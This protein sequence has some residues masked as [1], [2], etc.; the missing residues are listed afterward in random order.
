MRTFMRS[1]QMKRARGL[2]VQ[3][4]VVAVDDVRGG[5]ASAIDLPDSVADLVFTSSVLIH[6]HQDHLLSSCSEI[7]RCASRWIGCIE[8]FSDKPEMI[9]Y[10]GQDDQLFKCDLG[11]FWLDNFPDL[12]II[13]Y[14]F[15]WKRVTG[16]DNLTWWLFEKCR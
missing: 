4:G 8:Y 14:D 13:A 10:R 11:G 6:I 9:P 15:S 2:L 16:L 12:R 7:H 5:V 3:D 1:N